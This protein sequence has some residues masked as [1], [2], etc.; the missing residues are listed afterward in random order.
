MDIDTINVD[1]KPTRPPK[2]NAIGSNKVIPSTSHF[3]EASAPV[4]T[5]RPT[6]EDQIPEPEKETCCLGMTAG[7][8]FCEILAFVGCII[9]CPILCLGAVLP[10]K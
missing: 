7:E 6:A 2:I 8:W 4:I 10:D 5:E 1:S 9:C 3:V